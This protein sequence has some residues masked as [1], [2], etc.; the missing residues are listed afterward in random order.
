MRRPPSYSGFARCKCHR[1]RR[2]TVGPQDP[3]LHRARTYIA[4]VHRHA[5][6]P[7]ATRQRRYSPPTAARTR[8]HA[9]S[10]LAREIRSLSIL[11]EAASSANGTETQGWTMTT[12]ARVTS[13]NLTARGRSDPKRAQTPSY[14]SLAPKKRE[15]TGEAVPLA[16][17][18]LAAG[19]ES[20]PSP[21]YERRRATRCPPDTSDDARIST[22]GI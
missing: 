17:T 14:A 10:T 18:V 15:N 13:R 9:S 20:S 8:P 3:N 6:Y 19:S 2:L 5:A 16:L 4:R 11:T 22:T 1:V 12:A 21:M 7:Q